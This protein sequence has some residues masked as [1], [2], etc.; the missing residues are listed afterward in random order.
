MNLPELFE[1][2][3]AWNERSVLDTALRRADDAGE[4]ERAAQL[5][6]L[7]A[8]Q[9]RVP[10]VDALAAQHELTELLL[11]WRWHTVTA[12]REEGATWDAIAAATRTDPEQ[13]RESYRER[14]AEAEQAARELDL[15]LR[16]ADRYRAAAGDEHDAPTTEP[17]EEDR[18]MPDHDN[19]D[20]QPEMIAGPDLDDQGFVVGEIALP[21]GLPPEDEEDDDT[22]VG[23]HV[24]SWVDVE[25][26]PRRSQPISHGAAVEQDVQVLEFLGAKAET[27]GDHEQAAR[28]RQAA[29]A[30]RDEHDAW[31]AEHPE[32]AGELGQAGIN[33]RGWTHEQREGL[34]AARADL[35]GGYWQAAADDRADR[36]AARAL[37]DAHERDALPIP[38]RDHDTALRTHDGLSDDVVTGQASDLDRLRLRLTGYTWRE[39]VDRDE[40]LADRRQQLGYW[41]ALDGDDQ[42]SEQ[43]LDSVDGADGADGPDP[44]WYR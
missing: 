30:L 16:D 34:L 35:D 19:S 28:H 8:E 20:R 37:G 24:G 43:G 33:T 1:T 32:L 9:P 21:G 10:A 14:V 15:P 23:G 6:E 25:D 39:G 44:R 18:A 27:D 7:L 41:Y 3:R 11:G 31:A 17:L 26:D 36:L 42:A 22:E 40:A 5:R 4:Q 38:G 12:A 13:A 29:A 2:W